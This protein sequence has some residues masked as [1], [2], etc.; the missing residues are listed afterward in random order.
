MI[1]YLLIF[2]HSFLP[3][4]LEKDIPSQKKDFAWELLPPVA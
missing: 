3:A 1:D 4:F 2:D